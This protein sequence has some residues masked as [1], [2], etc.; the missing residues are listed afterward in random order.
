M[1]ASITTQ[2]GSP[3]VT[4]LGRLAAIGVTL[5]LA[6]LEPAVAAEPIDVRVG[7]PSRA[8]TAQT[9]PFAVAV[10]MGWFREQGIDVQLVPLAGSADCVKNVAS[11]AVPFALASPEPLAAGRLQGLRAKV[12]YTAYQ[13][14]I[15]VIAVPAASSIVKIADLKGRTIGVPSMGSNGVVIARALAAANGLDPETDITIV[16][17]GEAAQAAAMLKNHQVDALSQGDTQHAIVENAG[18][19]KLRLLDNRDI[20]RFPSDGFIALEETIQGREKEAVALARGYAMGTVF[21]LA[22][23]EAAIRILYE[24]WPQTRAPGKDDATA[25]RDDV[26]VLEARLQNLRLERSGARRWGENFEANYTAYM[27]FL[28]RSNILKERV[29]FR[30]LVTY[31]LIEQINR[32]DSGKIASEAR[33]Y[34]GSR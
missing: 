11:R 8:V 12:F 15:F 24:V 16:P 21:A 19:I 20:A 23:P 17:A 31:L 13:A 9:A 22:N 10:K 1:P 29:E 4:R 33:A 26:R 28:V 14:N 34:R 32:F 5:W 30:D 18:G 6:G 25:L 3:L 27:D 7:W 2:G